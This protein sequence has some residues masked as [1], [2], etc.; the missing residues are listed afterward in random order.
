MFI[1]FGLCMQHGWKKFAVA[2]IS[3]L[4]FTA[5]ARGETFRSYFK[6]KNK[7]SKVPV[8]DLLSTTP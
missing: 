4:N 7:K 1:S 5:S 6:G 3:L 8:L 2:P